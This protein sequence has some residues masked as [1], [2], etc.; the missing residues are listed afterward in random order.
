MLSVQNFYWPPYQCLHSHP[1]ARDICTAALRV[2][3]FC[4]PSP[5]PLW[6][7][8]Q[9]LVLFLYSVI[10]CDMGDSRRD[11]FRCFVN[12]Y[13]QVNGDDFVLGM[14]KG[15]KEEVEVVLRK[16]EMKTRYSLS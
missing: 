16:G 13:L 12:F 10:Y 4:T 11:I 1:G 8:I 2:F 3:Y 9:Y 5:F 15:N 14:D 6:T 7:V